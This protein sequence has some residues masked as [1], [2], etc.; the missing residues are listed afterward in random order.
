M[1]RNVREFRRKYQV[2]CVDEKVLKS[3]ITRQGYT[4]VEFNGIS[5]TEEVH[6]LIDAL[7]IEQYIRGCKCFT[8]QDNHFR[9]LFLHEKLSPDEQT[10]ILA[11]EEGHIWNKHLQT[12][13]I[14]GQDVMQE[15]EAN[16]FAHYLLN[17]KKRKLKKSIVA[18]ITVAALMLG[19][20]YVLFTGYKSSVY[21]DNLYITDSG[22]KYHRKDCIYIRNQNNVMKMTKEEFNSGEYEPCDVCFPDDQ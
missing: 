8:Y 17:E 15:H 7:G 5:E 16:E 3:I 1:K 11:H 14:L 21:T 12:D 9:I 10:I 22:E 19:L 2:H 13:G 6:T 20:L 18:I 4:I